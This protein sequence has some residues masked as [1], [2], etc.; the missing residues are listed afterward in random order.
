MKLII[1]PHADDEVLGCGGLLAKFHATVVICSDKSDGRMD[2]FAAA[3]GILG[4]FDTYGP[5]FKAGELTANARGLVTWLDGLVRNLKP[6]ELYLPT[7][8]MHQDH[9]AVYE[10]G[11]RAARKS[12]TSDAWFVPNVYLYE[13]PSYGTDLYNIPYTW[14]K[15]LKLDEQQMSLK[16]EAIRAYGSQSNGTFDPAKLARDHAEFIGAQVNVK[17]AE[18]YAVVREVLA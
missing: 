13:V 9:I 6:T 10:A 17:F 2:E 11:M 16:E 18:R 15:Y 14:N 1:A 8:G 12:Y 7:P 5:M 4:G 3:R